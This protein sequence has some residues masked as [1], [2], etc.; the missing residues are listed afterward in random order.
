M[1]QQWCGLAFTHLHNTSP[2]ARL[3]LAG[4]HIVTSSPPGGERDRSGYSQ[5]AGPCFS[6]ST[7]KERD[8]CGLSRLAGPRIAFSVPPCQR[9]WP[10]GCRHS[11]RHC[12]F[13]Q[14]AGSSVYSSEGWP[15]AALRRR[16][17]LHTAPLASSRSIF[18]IVAEGTGA[19]EAGGS[20]HLGWA[21]GSVIS[22]CNCR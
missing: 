15:L 6:S 2:R 22:T 9:R 11:A 16:F 13:S 5:L 4:L 21:D 20:S 3:L 17:S 18:R 14:L 8:R 7:P 19:C 1:Q 12:S 10:G